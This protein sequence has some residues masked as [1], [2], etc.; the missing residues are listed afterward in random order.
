VQLREHGGQADGAEL[1]DLSR[2]GER[3]EQLVHALEQQPR[4]LPI[5]RAARLMREA[6]GGHPA[7]SH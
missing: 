3:L 2:H 1:V 7:Q 6:I 4:E 5:R